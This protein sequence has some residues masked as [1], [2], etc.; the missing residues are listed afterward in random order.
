[1]HSTVNIANIGLTD[2]HNS[3]FPFLSCVLFKLSEEADIG[4]QKTMTAVIENLKMF[5]SCP[6]NASKSKGSILLA[7]ATIIKALFK[8]HYMFKYNENVW[9]LF[10]PRSKC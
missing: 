7:I 1:M 6:L 8:N 9:A 5:E 4:I 2:L 10:Y 3:R